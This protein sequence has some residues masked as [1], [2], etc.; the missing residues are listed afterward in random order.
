MGWRQVALSLLVNLGATAHLAA[1]CPDGSPPPCGAGTLRATR[2][3]NSVAVLYFD[4]LSPDTADAFLVDALTEAIIDRLARVPRLGVKSR[5]A[6]RR[7]RAQRIQDPDA[8]GRALKATY[9]VSGSVRRAEGRLKVTVELVRSS[10]GDRLWGE[11]YDLVERGFFRV[12]TEIAEAVAVAIIGRLLP[13]ERRALS[14]R[15]ARDLEAY[16]LYLKGRFALNRLTEQTVRSGLEYFKRAITLDSMFAPAFAGLADAYNILADYEPPRGLIDS[17]RA[18]AIRAVTLQ[19]NSGDALNALGWV[20]YAFEWNAPAA[21]ATFRR[22]VALAPTE[23]TPYLRLSELLAGQRRFAEALAAAQSAAELDSSN[24]R[25]YVG[26]LILS[27]RYTEAVAAAQAFA[28]AD[29]TDLVNRFLLGFTQVLLHRCDEGLGELERA[30]ALQPS[31]P[32]VVATMANSYAGCGKNAEA[33]RVLA[34]LQQR[35]QSGYVPAV[36]LA[37]AFAGLGE[38]DSA[39]FW[40]ER[41]ADDRAAHIMY[42]NV[43]PMWDPLRLDPRFVALVRRAGLEIR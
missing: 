42:L 35:R 3:S 5:E 39:F 21:E 34:E 16:R 12:E 9:L 15:P 31:D 11:R 10:S 19:P 33:R 2:Q 23:A 6:V 1:Q 18:A 36:S 4:N 7:F 38:R 41:A 14:Q 22:A 37:Y 24:A 30:R 26:V 28:I 25:N 20:Q 27:R 29:P 17:M 43:Q 32:Y 8:L 13:V 40:L